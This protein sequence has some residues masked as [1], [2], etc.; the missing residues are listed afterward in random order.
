MS[1]PSSFEGLWCPKCESFYKSAQIIAKNCGFRLCGDLYADTLAFKCL[2][3]KHPTILSYS[4]RLQGN[5]KCAG[6]R[7]DERE[8][9]KERLRAEE[10]VQDAYYAEMQEK[11][12]AEARQEMQKEFSQGLYSNFKPTSGSMF[13]DDAQRRNIME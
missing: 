2:K 11:M 8:T 6:C 5:I 1:E 12:F 4:R 3:A 9:V 13:M 7:K 10:R